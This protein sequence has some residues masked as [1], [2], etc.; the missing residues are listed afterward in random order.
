M[1]LAGVSIPSAYVLEG[2]VYKASGRSYVMMI[3]ALVTSAM[4]TPSSN[5]WTVV[6]SIKVVNLVMTLPTVAESNQSFDYTPKP[7]HSTNN[8]GHNLL[9][10]TI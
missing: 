9:F 7:L 3:T 1:E 4:L 5:I 6:Q 8:L 10:V 2:E